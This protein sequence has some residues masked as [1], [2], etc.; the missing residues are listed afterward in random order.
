MVYS[1][2]KKMTSNTEITQ[3]T[4]NLAEF[5]INDAKINNNERNMF[6]TPPPTIVDLSHPPLAPLRL[7]KACLTDNKTKCHRIIIRPKP[8][9]SMIKSEI[10]HL[11]LSDQITR[12]EARLI[13]TVLDY[14][15]SDIKKL[16]KEV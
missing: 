10:L 4:N 9:K 7:P 3:I 14:I 13:T 15:K 8:I 6:T 1:P 16:K 12:E 2:K 11:I 5:K